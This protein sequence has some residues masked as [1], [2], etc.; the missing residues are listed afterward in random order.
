MKAV[1][2]V[3][4]GLLVYCLPTQLQ[5]TVK[6]ASVV[7]TIPSNGSWDIIT[8]S[9]IAVRFSK[10][11]TEADFQSVRINVSGDVSAVQHGSVVL[12]D[13][14]RT[15][16]FK[17]DVPFAEGEKVTV[18]VVSSEDGL[19]M[20]AALYIFSFTVAKGDRM[21]SV[22]EM[23][24]FEMPKQVENL[25][26]T[27]VDILGG[28]TIEPVVKVFSKGEPAPGKIFLSCFSQD[29]TKNY[30]FILNNDG[31][32]VFAQ[33]HSKNCFDFKVQPTGQLSYYDIQ[34]TNFAVMDSG[35]HIRDRIAAG[36]GLFTDIHE[37]RLLPNHHALLIG[38]LG[39]QKD[40]S[41]LV[42]KG[43]SKA[44]LVE[45]VLQ[46]LDSSKNIVFEFR[47]WEHYNVLSTTQPLTDTLIDYIHPNA[48]EL[49]SDGN[50]LISC[51]HLEE[52]TKVSRT[53][54]EVM[55]RWGGKHDDFRWDDTLHFSHQ[56]GIRRLSGGNLILFDNGNVIH[57][58]FSRAVEYTMDESKKTVR[59]AWEYRNSPDFYSVAMGDVQ[60]LQNGN[61][62]IGWGLIWDSTQTASEIDA[63]GKKIME[64]VLPPGCHSYR[65][66]RFDWNP[67]V[68]AGVASKAATPA[69]AGLS[70]YPNPGST[71]MH[72]AYETKQT[73][74]S[75]LVVRDILGHMMTTV[76]AGRMG[77]GMHELQ[78]NCSN[79]PAGIYLFGLEGSN[80]WQRMT[81]VR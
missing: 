53:T 42:A 57:P 20:L 14:Q 66:Y 16:I 62:F 47:S 18:T 76:D 78:I 24:H 1:L 79:W 33:H 21:L 68:G 67:S 36:P 46:E 38:T 10:D 41:K 27:A 19:Q 65:C 70:S 75:R 40:M 15:V 69:P 54:G 52:I 48:I 73:S 6:P 39:R 43:D 80:S 5:A 60:R 29:S 7:Y 30:L 22:A 34:Y 17:P 56:H 49:D 8:Q 31:T 2:V 3:L 4:A 32:P 77:S 71:I 74:S 9:A 45:F 28:E 58:G 25:H 35:Y 23:M 61:T 26:K 50:I 51:R 11:L 12:S 44:F 64:V 81:I 63:A 72:I 59:K 37:L 13:D 55:W